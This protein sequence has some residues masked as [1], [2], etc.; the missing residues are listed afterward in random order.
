MIAEA[1]ADHRRALAGVAALLWATV[2]LLWAYEVHVG[3]LPA[4][5]RISA[6]FFARPTRPGI[7]QLATGVVRLGDPFVVALTLLAA[8]WVVWTTMGPRL[9]ALVPVAGIGAAVGARIAKAV[10]GPTPYY[11][12]LSPPANPAGNLPS[13][14]TSY[15]AALFGL[16]AAYA[17]L[18]RRPAA[19]LALSV[20][21]LAMGPSLVLVGSHVP[22]DVLAGYAFGAGWVLLLLAVAVPRL[23]SPR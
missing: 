16:L 8:V 6:H 7:A 18:R 17:L 11:S 14:H 12:L 13:G 9:A 5:E 19:A 4:E 3:P 1:I 21:A 22:S 23:S 15:A 10:L 20:P 2:P